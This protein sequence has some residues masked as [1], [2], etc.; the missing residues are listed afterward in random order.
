MLHRLAAFTLLLL[1]T[2]TLRAQLA[3]NDGLPALDA[4]PNNPTAA[5]SAWLD[6]RQNKP[7]NSKAQ[8]APAWVEAVSLVN[9]QM[10]DGSPKA[11][12][13]IRVS[14]PAGDY[15][16]LFFRLF[17]DD[18][19]TRGPSWFVGMNRAHKFFGPAHWARASGS[20][21]RIPR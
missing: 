14:H 13:R 1:A 16:I 3:L 10:A 7:A 11:I 6:L 2:A 20:R 8:S 21:V 4:T 19:T 15:Q 9:G 18:L 5:D 12:F 17:F